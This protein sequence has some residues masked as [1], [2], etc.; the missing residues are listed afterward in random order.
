MS[1]EIVRETISITRS[2]AH[3][4][5]EEKEIAG[6]YNKVVRRGLNQALHLLQ[7]GTPEQKMRITTTAIQ[8]ASRLAA[9]ESASEI[10][11]AR[12]EFERLVSQVTDVGGT[13]PIVISGPDAPPPTPRFIDAPSTA[14]AIGPDDQD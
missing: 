11:E 7:W 9:L 1:E 8:S 13:S 10:E 14:V 2:S 6:L 12:L 3:V 4:S 5:D